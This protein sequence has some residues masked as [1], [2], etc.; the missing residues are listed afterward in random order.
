MYVQMMPS[1]C[2]GSG[3][4]LRQTGALF[5]FGMGDYEETQS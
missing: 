2:V 4:E 5:E 1:P 3:V